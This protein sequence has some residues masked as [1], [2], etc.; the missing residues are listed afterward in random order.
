FSR[1][2]IP[3]ER[4]CVTVRERNPRISKKEMMKLSIALVFLGLCV[5]CSADDPKTPAK[6]HSAGSIT[7][8]QRLRFRE[9]ERDYAQA[10]VTI[11]QAQ[12]QQAAAQTAQAQQEKLRTEGQALIASMQATC[13]KDAEDW[14][15]TGLKCNPKQQAQ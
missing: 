15:A 4:V 2:Q 6:N 7:D 1:D 9:T 13:K 8:A 14:D 3:Q 10:Q 12:A 5:S 11:T